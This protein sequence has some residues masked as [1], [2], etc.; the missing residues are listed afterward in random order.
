MSDP[1]LVLASQSKTR[2]QMLSAAG[3]SY[4][5]AV[6]KVDEADL[7][8][9]FKSKNLTPIELANELA[10]AKALGTS[11][12]GNDLMILGGDQVL[13]F[14]NGEFLNKP[15][16]KN[17]AKAQLLKMS[18]RDHKLYSAAALAHGGSVIWSDVDIATMSV[19]KLSER[20]IDDYV[21]EQW[22]NIRHCVGCYEIEG[23]G[24]QLFSRIEGSQFTIMG[25]PLLPLLAFLR[26]QRMMPS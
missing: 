17:I 7:K 26:K 3:I 23:L 9:R 15:T 11:D 12:N 16:N 1:I 5:T 19:R 22:E 21:E 10:A 18:N 8:E 24:V 20:L 13:A 25:L 2:Q 4:V 6:P 14:E